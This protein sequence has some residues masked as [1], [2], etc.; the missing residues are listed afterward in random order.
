MGR[1]LLF[2][3]LVCG[4]G[5]WK[6]ADSAKI[7]CKICKEFVVSFNKVKDQ[8]RQEAPTDFVLCGCAVATG[9]HC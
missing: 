8:G 3:L 7:T 9:G 2:L 1:E 6:E 5:L 4:A